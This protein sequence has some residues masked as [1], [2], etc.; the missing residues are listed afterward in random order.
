MSIQA[1]PAVNAR[2]GDAMLGTW[3][4][5]SLCGYGLTTILWLAEV[6]NQGWGD[7]SW[8]APTIVAVGSVLVGLAGKLPP[9]IRAWK[10]EPKKPRA[11]RKTPRKTD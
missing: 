4:L 11:P 7:K 3:T 2:A 8:F 5:L 6:V 10:E 1:L 9:I